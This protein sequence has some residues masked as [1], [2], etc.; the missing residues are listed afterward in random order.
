MFAIWGVFRWQRGQ[1]RSVCVDIGQERALIFLWWQSLHILVKRA[2]QRQLENL[3]LSSLFCSSQ[4]NMCNL[5]TTIN[6]WS[7]PEGNN[8][9]PHIFKPGTRKESTSNVQ[10]QT[11]WEG[12]KE[13]RVSLYKMLFQ[14]LPKKDSHSIPKILC[15]LYEKVIFSLWS[16]AF[17]SVV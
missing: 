15:E 9:N 5:S 16:F 7:E 14:I 17:T 10:L 13:E 2:D 4:D 8:L 6:A 1:A 12:L 3:W 11:C